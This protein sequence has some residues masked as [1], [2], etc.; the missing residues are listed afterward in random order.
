MSTSRMN[1]WR[2]WAVRLAQHASSV[3]PGTRSPW[4]EAMRRELDYIADDAAALRWAI[5]CVFASYRTRLLQWFSPRT[6]WRQ[7]AASGALMVLLALAVH[8]NAG[9]QTEPPRP[10]PNETACEPPGASPVLR[11]DRGG[12]NRTADIGR[13]TCRSDRADPPPP[14]K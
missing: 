6:S 4:A 13:R 3:L 11:Q 2:R 14:K 9:G 7:I 1:G 8:D 10:E 5:G 12:L